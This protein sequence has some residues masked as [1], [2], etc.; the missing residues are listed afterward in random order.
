MASPGGP[1]AVRT[2]NFALVGS[3]KLTLASIGK[4]K[5]SLEKV[6]IWHHL[7]FYLNHLHCVWHRL[8]AYQQLMLRGMLVELSE[9]CAGIRPTYR[10]VKALFSEGNIQT[11]IFPLWSMLPR[12]HSHI[13]FSLVDQIWRIWESAS[14]WHV[15]EKG[16]YLPNDIFAF[17]CLGEVER[18]F[19]AALVNPMF[20][21]GTNIL[22][23]IVQHVSTML[24]EE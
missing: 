19:V 3:H 18:R 23:L 21:R 4:N 10:L 16:S 9:L 11:S 14:K 15:S 13:H 22:T 17:V 20:H 7:G 24:Q 2:S 5:Y 1:N 6:F 12:W 8:C